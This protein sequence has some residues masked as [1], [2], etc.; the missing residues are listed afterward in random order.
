MTLRR[1]VH[2]GEV[3]VDGVAGVLLT[4]GVLP[5]DG[6]ELDAAVVPGA[7]FVAQVAPLRQG[8]VVSVVSH[9]GR[10]GDAGLHDQLGPQAVHLDTIT[11]SFPFLTVF[12]VI[13]A[14]AVVL[15]LRRVAA[16]LDRVPASVDTEREALL[17]E[18]T[19]EDPLVPG[20]AEALVDGPGGLGRGAV[21]LPVEEEHHQHGDEEGAEGRVHHVP[22][23]IR[24]LARE[25]T[26]PLVIQAATVAAAPH[27][28]HGR[29]R[30]DEVLV[31]IVPA[32]E[33]RE[34]DDEGRDPHG[35]DEELGT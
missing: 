30:R 31:T 10:E 15:P 27:V 6:E 2:L 19:A 28:G 34:A 9:V 18:A 22:H 23:V 14:L 21:D 20:G 16:F 17:L 29:G 35:G 25:V 13:V 11:S 5:A 8:E 4:V 26:R 24:Q 12:P 33:G 32:D 1:G 3:G 7:L